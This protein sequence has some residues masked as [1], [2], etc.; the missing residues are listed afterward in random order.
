MLTDRADLGRATWKFLHTLTMLFPE[1][2]T[3]QQSRDFKEFFRLFSLLYPCGDCA[4]HFQK[5]L[6]DMPPQAGS[7]RNAAIWLCNAHN[8]GNKR[9]GHPQFD[10]K[11]LDSTYDCGCGPESSADPLANINPM[12]ATGSAHILPIPH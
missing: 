9:L 7:R 2:P 6:K 12:E 8:V 5:L 1:N 4:A 3:P 11:N 10:C